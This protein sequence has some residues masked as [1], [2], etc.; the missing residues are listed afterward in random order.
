MAR[1]P[2]FRV[3]RPSAGKLLVERPD[4]HTGAGDGS[5]ATLGKVEVRYD[6]RFGVG[7]GVV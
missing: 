5:T 1:G 3:D 2:W 4:G 6:G 7:H